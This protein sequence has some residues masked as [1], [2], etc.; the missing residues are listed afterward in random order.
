MP[1]YDDAQDAKAHAEEMGKMLTDFMKMA[2]AIEIKR[3]TE[4]QIEVTLL[5]KNKKLIVRFET[6]SLAIGDSVEFSLE[7]RFI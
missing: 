5:D 2:K 6:V 4:N 7:G 3:V 1:I